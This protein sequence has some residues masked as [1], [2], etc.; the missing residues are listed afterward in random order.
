[1][2]IER[3]ALSALFLFLSLSIFSEEKL[4]TIVHTNDMHSHLQ[5]FAPELDYTPFSV[6]D[7]ATVGG[8]AR[9]A[10]VIREVRAERKNPV[11]VLDAGDFLMGSLF[12][13]VSREEAVELRL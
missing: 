9:I 4:F 13:M 3:V 11:L 5:G 7:D 1:M 12:H 8:W 10:T 6:N 2:R